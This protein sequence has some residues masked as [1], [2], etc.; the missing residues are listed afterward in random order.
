LRQR[1]SK[2]CWVKGYRVV[3]AM[4]DNVS[5]ELKFAVNSLG[6]HLLLTPVADGMTGAVEAARALAESTPGA[7]MPQQF[8]NPAN[9]NVHRRTTAHEIL[10]ATQG[11]LDAFVAGIGTGGTIT[12]VAQIIKQENADVLAVGVEPAASPLLT[13]GHAGHHLIQ[14]IGANFVPEVLD[15]GVIDRLFPVADEDAFVTARRLAREEGIFAGVSAGAAAFAALQVA[16]ELG[17]GK[18]VVVLL[19]D[20]GDRYSSLR[21]YF[22]IDEQRRPERLARRPRSGDAKERT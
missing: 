9:P 1:K 6:A 19:P 10:E 22:E 2:D 16:R 5:E 3:L 4:P 8:R 20:T 14:G 17:R 7:Y 11:Q 13:E 18:R 15:V 21:S 12:G